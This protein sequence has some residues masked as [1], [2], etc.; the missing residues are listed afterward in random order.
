MLGLP[1]ILVSD[2]GP[3]LR[4]HNSQT[5]TGRMAS[6]TC[7]TSAPFDPTSYREAD[8]LV[9]VFKRAMQRSVGRKVWDKT[10]PQEN[11]SENIVGLLT[12]LTEE[13]LPS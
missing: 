2:K 11:S 10:R 6:C 9:G 12:V 3:H 1:K 7:M 13:H 5:G 4:Q 8:R